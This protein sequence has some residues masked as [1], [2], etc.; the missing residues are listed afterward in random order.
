MGYVVLC[1]D[2]YYVE[3]MT[4]YFVNLYGRPHLNGWKLFVLVC[5]S[6]WETGDDTRSV[7]GVGTLVE[8]KQIGPLSCTSLKLRRRPYR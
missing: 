4:L 8:V 7:R 2:F 1:D 6:I 5:F 3:F